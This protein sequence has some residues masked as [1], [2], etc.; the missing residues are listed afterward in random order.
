MII[1]EM[2]KLLEERANSNE[3]DGVCDEK[4]PYIRCKECLAVMVLNE[5]SEILRQA[6]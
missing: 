2:V 1:Q 3:C 6:I 5:I 4:P